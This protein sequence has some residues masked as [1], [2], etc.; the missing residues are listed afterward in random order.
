MRKLFLVFVIPVLLAA[1]PAAAAGEL[2]LT[3]RDG[4]VTL[5]ADGVPLSTIMAEWA[6]I[7][8]TKIINGEKITTPVTLQII[9]TPERKALDIVL[10]AASGYM[11]AER[12]IPVA[13]ASAFDRIMILPTSQAPANTGPIASP[14]PAFARQPMPQPMPM[15]N[16]DDDEP[17]VPPGM[18]PQ[19]ATGQ[20][21]G[22]TPVQGQPQGPLTSPR[23]G[24]L[25]PPAQPVPFGT[26][27]SPAVKPPGGGGPGGGPGG[28]GL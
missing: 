11:A 9:D 16:P 5:K 28:G 19:P 4:L 6:R 2:Q 23:P 27:T 14:P 15:V 21:A 13:G 26:P 1:P 25:P 8:Q 3:I 17:A 22:P 10:R 24:F 12:P 18:N 20:P 7:G